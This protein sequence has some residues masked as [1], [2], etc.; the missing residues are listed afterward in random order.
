[1]ESLVKISLSIFGYISFYLVP[2]FPDLQEDLKKAKYRR[3]AFEHISLSLFVGLIGFVASHPFTSLVF[4]VFLRSAIA[5]YM[6]SVLIS[7]SIFFGSFF[8]SV[9]YPKTVAKSIAKEVD[10]YLPFISLNLSLL[11]SAR[12]PID[13][14]FLMLER[15]KLPKKVT[16]ELNPLINDI[17]VFGIDITKALQRAIDRCSS[18]NFKELLFGIYSLVKSG[19]DLSPYLKEK[20]KSYV[21][22]YRRNLLDFSRKLGMFTQIY[23]MAIIISSIFF[24]V[25]LTVFGAIT[26]IG[27]TAVLIQMFIIVGIIPLVSLMFIFLLKSITPTSLY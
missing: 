3:Q 6:L 19:G 27:E 10:S 1:M 20:A 8:F 22:E 12:I 18:E 16:I 23:L 11:A 9:K 25:L 5:G 24:T 17:K 4:S 26:G 7:F 2:L 13:K 14:A 15:F 21:A